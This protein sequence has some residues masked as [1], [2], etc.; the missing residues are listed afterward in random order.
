MHFIA[1]IL[2]CDDGYVARLLTF[3]FIDFLNIRLRICPCKL[4]VNK[5][6]IT[7]RKLS[8]QILFYSIANDSGIKKLSTASVLSNDT[9]ASSHIDRELHKCRWGKNRDF[10]I[11]GLCF[12]VACIP[13]SH[14]YVTWNHVHGF[15]RGTWVG[16]NFLCFL[17][18]WRQYEKG[19]PVCSSPCSE[20][21]HFNQLQS[22]DTG[23]KIFPRVRPGIET[24]EKMQEWLKKLWKS[25]PYFSTSQIFLRLAKVLLQKIW[26]SSNVTEC[27][28]YKK[29]FLQ[30]MQK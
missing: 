3:N 6:K 27:S 25:F 9:F 14:V 23:C 13:G 24:L 7:Y 20:E 16:E 12:Y 29:S 19:P 10:I 2:L 21:T 26:D 22:C 28:D 5:V 30:L 15:P 8:F 4:H 17:S 18:K 1:A 11:S